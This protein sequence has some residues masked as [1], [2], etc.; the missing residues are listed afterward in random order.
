MFPRVRL[1]RIGRFLRSQQIAHIVV[2]NARAVVGV[3]EPA[4]FADERHQIGGVRRVQT[5]YTLGLIVGNAHRHPPLLLMISVYHAA[6]SLG[7][8]FFAA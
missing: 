5:K 4:G 6:L 2:R 7:M 1:G 3:P 8:R